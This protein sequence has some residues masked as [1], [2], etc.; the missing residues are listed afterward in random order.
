MAQIR[1]GI[2]VGDLTSDAAV[3][4]GDSGKLPRGN[5]AP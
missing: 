4:T 2:L 1:D 3:G 5:Q